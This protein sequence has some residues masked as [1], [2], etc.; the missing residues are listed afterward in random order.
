MNRAPTSLR[1]R[2]AGVLGL[3]FLGGMVILYV[4]ANSYA[5]LASDR[6]Y[7]RLLAGSALS[8]A[9]T[10]SV[11][12][13]K[14][15]VDI[16]YAALDMLSAAPEDRVFYRV[17]G[18]NGATVTGYEDLPRAV[19][20]QRRGRDAA[21]D[22][23]IFFD[24][25]YR[26][27][28]VRFVSLDREVAQSP[29]SGHVQV[30]VGQTRRAR[31][32]LARD[33][34]IRALLPIAVMTIIALAV[35]WFGI[36]LALRPLTRLGRELAAR[37]PDDLTPIADGG[38]S[39]ISAVVS[40]LNEF[41]RR[42]GT[43]IEILRG[44]VADAAHQV[45]TPLAAI[46]TRAELAGQES[47]ADMRASIGMIRRSGARLTR[48]VNQLLSDATMHHRSDVRRFGTFDLLGAVREAVNDVVP[49]S[50]DS[51][52]RLRT[53]L[54]SANFYGDAVMI[55]EA[56]KNLI[57]NALTHG[58]ADHAEVTLELSAVDGG[59]LLSVGDRG[60][61]FPD[62]DRARLFERFARGHASSPGAG[63]G[64]AI[65]KQAAET[66]QGNVRLEDRPGG[67]A[68]VLLFLKGAA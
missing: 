20:P 25:V 43:N 15:D 8:I 45:R 54:D 56:V 51:D 10:L 6:S 1:T 14:V 49:R 12:G 11:V 3:V 59:Y 31:T 32:E 55:G 60:P 66:H 13:G 26:G 23:P 44:F 16:P 65:A 62:K 41:M 19:L 61:G 35:V 48:L 7:D 67:G 68:N 64:L 21:L 2:L 42:L 38:P 52:V 9:E 29:L 22:Q 17:A 57:H 46:M 34:V 37:T 58:R 24:A 5:R 39:E 28:P 40:A 47:E 50:E 63:L 53:S 33:L 36:D 4:A 27:E 18:L 30:Q